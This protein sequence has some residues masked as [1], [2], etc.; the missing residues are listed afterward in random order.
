MK[1]GIPS[2]VPHVFPWTH[3]ESVRDTSYITRFQSSPVRHLNNVIK[4]DP[5]LMKLKY[6]LIFYPSVTFLNKKLAITEKMNMTKISNA[7]TLN[8]D[9]NEINIV[10]N[11][12]YKLFNDL[13]NFNM[14][15]IRKT[16]NILNN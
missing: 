5:K 6:W 10:S 15:V 7:P 8:I 14:R 3:P 13:T 4:L 12:L 11:I 9:G 1:N 2:Y 16:L